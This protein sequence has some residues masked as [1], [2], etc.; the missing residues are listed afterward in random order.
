MP[1]PVILH[2]DVVDFL[3]TYSHDDLKESIGK[4][5]N[6]LR[7]QQFDGGLRVKKLK[8]ITKRVWE[9]RVTRAVRLIFTYDRSKKPDTGKAQTYIA[10]RDICSDHDDVSRRTK[11]RTKSPDN[12]WL[13]SELVE[14][15]G[16]IETERNALPAD[17]RAAIEILETEEL[18][19]SE[20]FKDELLSNIQW[21]VLESESEWQQAIMQRNID[22]P[23]KLTPEE[24]ELVNLYGNLFLSG[25]AGTGKTTVGL[26]RLLKSLETFPATSK[27]LYVASNPVLVRDAEKQFKRLV[28]AGFS[29]VS[30]MFQFKTIRDLCSEILRTAGENYSEFDEVTYQ[31]FLQLYSRHKDYKKY[32]PALV[33][34][35]IRSKIEGSCLKTDANL[36]TQKEY[37]NLGR[38][39]SIIRPNERHKIYRLAEWY[40]EYLNKEGR[41][42][43]IDLARQVLKYI[44]C[45]KGDRYQMIVCDEVQDLT[46]IQLHLLMRLVTADAHL[47]FAGDLNQLVSPS[48]FRWENLKTEFFNTKRQVVQK[49]LNFNFR[50]VGTLVQL[51]SQL[52]KLRSRLL[53]EKNNK[54]EPV[55]SSY[56]ECAR[57]IEA[58]P[59]TLPTAVKQLYPEDAVLVRTEEDKTRLSNDFQSSFVFTIEEAKGLEFDTVFL[60]DFF[61]QNESLWKKALAG[62]STIRNVERPQLQLELNLLYVAITRARRILNIWETSLSP[63]W[64]QKELA[65]F[66]Q[67]INPESIRQTEVEPTPQMWRDRGSYYLMNELYRQAAECFEKSGDIQLKQE[68]LAKLYLQE[69]KYSE[70]IE[71]LKELNNWQ[72]TAQ[73]FEEQ[74]KWNDAAIYWSKAGNTEKQRLCEIYAL[75]AENKWEDAARK[76]E[77]I[78]K[79]EEAKKCW[80]KSNNNQ[81]KA[82]IKAIEFEQK[83]QWIQAAEQ[84]EFARMPNKAAE[85]KAKEYEKKEQ[86]Q[87]A[88]EQYDLARMSEKARDCRNK[89]ESLLDVKETKT[90]EEN[91]QKRSPTEVSEREVIS[92][93]KHNAMTKRL[94][95]KAYVYGS[96][97][98]SVHT[99]VCSHPKLFNR[100]FCHIETKKH[101][102]TLW[103]EGPFEQSSNY[104][105][106]LSGSLSFEREWSNQFTIEIV[107]GEIFHVQK[108]FTL[109]TLPDID[110]NVSMRAMFTGEP[111][112]RLEIEGLLSTKVADDLPPEEIWIQT[113]FTDAIHLQNLITLPIEEAISWM[114]KTLENR[115]TPATFAEDINRWYENGVRERVSRAVQ[116]K[117]EENF[118]AALSIYG[119]LFLEMPTWSALYSSVYKVLALSGKIDE[120]ERAIQINAL[121]LAVD[122]TF[123]KPAVPWDYSFDSHRATAKNDRYGL[124]AFWG[125]QDP[126]LLMHLGAITLLKEG[127]MDKI[128]KQ[129]YLNSLRGQGSI[130]GCFSDEILQNKGREVLM[131]VPWQ[132][133]SNKQNVMPLIEIVINQI[134]EICF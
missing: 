108:R 81:K 25:S 79:L 73:I 23:L 45:G 86:W 32:P 78:E 90:F 4:C 18:Q 61:T 5:I 60:V 43:E 66:L 37:E 35:E 50:S 98:R 3:H 34:N 126:T 56:G 130:I 53:E 14:T 65:G 87:L 120:A 119:D 83:E 12:Q 121:L 113:P 134:E 49:T 17:E 24:Y 99:L 106:S 94:T 84:Y 103:S 22:L 11:A 118:E 6:K 1:L 128:A 28:D 19:I 46:Q 74:E 30:S 13:D 39:T 42:D 40:R 76:W 85:S 129:G 96:P 104:D 101:Q 89:H 127:K 2:P 27:R 110:P 93:I 131:E 132:A 20:N 8:G 82:E 64:S 31:I 26:Y 77:K 123:R 38:R 125:F 122:Y 21:R 105:T 75:E 33:W 58:S 114:S 36:L 109:S 41:F 47:F 67:P 57:L 16:S 111:V 59:N 133:I 9:A 52:L 92:R 115:H 102:I 15:I 71:F 54:L 68:S 117:R 91:E 51:A 10:V 107:N 69:R 44:D 88:A 97:V 95:E 63:V 7:Q 62:R 29:E 116:Y 72:Q 100:G 80:L 124:L 48:G 112:D 70:A 55:V